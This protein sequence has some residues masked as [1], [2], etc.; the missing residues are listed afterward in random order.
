M[1]LVKNIVIGFIGLVVFAALLG[2]CLPDDTGNQSEPTVEESEPEPEPEPESAPELGTYGSDE[3]FDGLY[4]DC[5][6]GNVDACD[7]LF[8][9]S[10][11]DS[12]YEAY[13]LERLGELE[14]EPEPESN[15]EERGYLDNLSILCS[16]GDMEACD[17]LYWD[18]PV[19][20]EYEA[21]GYPYAAIL[22]VW[23]SFTSDEQ[24]G[25]CSLYTGQPNVFLDGFVEGSEGEFSRTE[26]ERFFDWAC[27]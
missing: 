6:A 17:D 26:A 3:Y 20:S 25:T 14:P 2:M 23:Q 11:L 5:E 24:E 16:E 8:W 27:N 9:D 10:P 12:E 21:Q 4:D 1:K 18:S 7:E 15:T 22:L 13:A 19:D